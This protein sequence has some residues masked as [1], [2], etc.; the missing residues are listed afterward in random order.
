MLNSGLTSKGFFI[1]KGR[2]EKIESKRRKQ[3]I[4]CHCEGVYNNKSRKSSKS[5]RTGC[6]WHVNLSKP[7]KNNLNGM[8]FITTIFNGHIGHNLD[9][10]AC[11]FE[12]SKAFTKPMLKDI[13]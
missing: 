1:R 6:K 7:I 8:I 2:S 4:V 9:P 5:Y 3:T 12:V 11:H 13:E 10:S